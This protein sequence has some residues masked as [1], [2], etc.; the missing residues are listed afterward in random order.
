VQEL[1]GDCQLAGDVTLPA[2]LSFLGLGTQPPTPSWG[3]MLNE[4]Q[5]F[6]EFGSLAG[7]FSRNCHHLLVL[8]LLIL[9]GMV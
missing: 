3:L 9:L 6:M 7:R 8:L 5:R 4:S 1:R 2:A